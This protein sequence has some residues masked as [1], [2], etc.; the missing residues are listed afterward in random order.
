MITME[1]GALAIVSRVIMKALD[2]GIA[3]T[4]FGCLWT[5]VAMETGPLATVAR[6]IMKALY[7]CILSHCLVSIELRLQWKLGPRPRL[8]SRLWKPL[9]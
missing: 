3:S 2:I 8:L 9:I 4:S 6:V 1:A 7:T 5:A